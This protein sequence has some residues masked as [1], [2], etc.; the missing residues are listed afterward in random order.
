MSVFSD[1]FGAGLDYLA[2]TSGEAVTYI[3]PG[4]KKK[5]CTAI[6]GNESEELVNVQNGQERHRKRQFTFLLDEIDP[7]IDAT[8][9]YGGTD[10]VIVGES[11]RSA[12]HARVI[13]SSVPLHEGTR[14]GFRGPR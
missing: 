4:G 10:W 5:P 9:R 3:A 14:P 12:T 6:V 13:G 2:D 1:Q 11:S 8:V 7:V